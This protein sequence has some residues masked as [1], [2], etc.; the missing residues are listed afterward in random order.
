MTITQKEEVIKSKERIWIGFG[1]G[2]CFLYYSVRVYSIIKLWLDCS[3]LGPRTLCGFTTNHLTTIIVSNILMNFFLV[4]MFLK[5]S[6]MIRKSIE[7]QRLSQ[8]ELRKGLEVNNSQL[9]FFSGVSV[10][11]VIVLCYSF[12]LQKE[13]FDSTLYGFLDNVVIGGSRM[14]VNLMLCYLFVKISLKRTNVIYQID[15]LGNIFIVK[16]AKSELLCE[17]DP[18]SENSFDGLPRVT[19]STANR[20]DFEDLTNSNGIV[21]S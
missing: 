17:S 6:Y 21:S 10:L 9:Y 12:Y 16:P 20:I 3:A 11:I 8:I 13:R 18:A 2:V 7:E 1:F 14:I 5:S 19:F 4:L 15:S